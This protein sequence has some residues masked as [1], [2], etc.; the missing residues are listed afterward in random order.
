MREGKM[1]MMEDKKRDLLQRLESIAEDIY[2]FARNS[3]PE[4]ESLGANV[5]VD[6]LVDYSNE[7]TV[8]VRE[9]SMLEVVK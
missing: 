5:D 3:E 2:L 8:I 6:D 4:I 7:I 1:K 9:M